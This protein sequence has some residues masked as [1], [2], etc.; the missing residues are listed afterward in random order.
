MAFFLKGVHVPH[1]KN[2][3]GFKGVKLPA[4]KQVAIPTSMHIGAPAKVVVSVGDEVKIG[5]LIAE[6]SGVVSSNVYSSVSGKVVKIEDM[7]LSSG[8]SA[9]AIMIESD[10]EM[11][12]DENVKPPVINSAEDL[13]EAIRLSG[14]VGLGGAGFPTYVKFGANKP[15]KI[16]ELIING[17]E[18]EPYITSDSVT[19]VEKSNEIGYALS[20]LTSFFEIDRVIIGIEK[21]KPD[22]IKAMKKL[23]NDKIKVRVLPSVYPQ[24]GEKVLVYHLTGKKIPLGKLPID[25]G[26]VVCNSTTV[27]TIGTY[28]LTGM[29]LVE[30]CITVDGDAVKTPQNVIAPIGCALQE[31]FD[32]CGGFTKPVAKV[33]YGGPMMGISVPDTSVPVLKMTNAILAFSEK[34]N[35]EAD[36]TA[37]IKCGSCLNHCPFGINPVA[38]AASLKNNDLEGL[39]KAGAQ[40]CMECGCCAFVCPAKRPIVQNNKLAKQKLQQAN[41]KGGK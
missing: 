24:G 13:L 7:L 12:I 1:R 18:C 40:L 23:E 21:N 19:M 38:I 17:A 10:G 11:A 2:T 34:L 29:P 32:F 39:K 5:T 25:V 35:K 31:V 28:L 26:C 9:P 14:V 37:C 33:I 36:P 3:A 30:K 41:A 22:A 4:P 8:K 20:V 16:Q 27:A 6:Q 15:V